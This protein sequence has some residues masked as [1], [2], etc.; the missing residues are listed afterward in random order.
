MGG[1]HSKRSTAVS[2]PVNNHTGLSSVY[3]DDLNSRLKG[4][5]LKELCQRPSAGLTEVRRDGKDN[6][7]IT[8]VIEDEF[9]RCSE[10][11]DQMEF[12]YHMRTY[13]TACWATM[14]SLHQQFLEDETPENER[15][16]LDPDHWYENNL[17]NAGLFANLAPEKIEGMEELVPGRLF[18]TRMP[19]DLIE[20]PGE[21]KD[22]LDKV[23]ENELKVICVLTEAHEFEKY[24][25]DDGLIEFYEKEC[26]LTVYNRAIPDFEIPASGDLVN[27]ILD[28]TYHLSQGRNALIHCAGGTGRTGM[29]LAGVIKNLG[30]YDPVARIR[31]VKSTYVETVEQEKFLRDMPK[32]IDSRIVEEK[33][34]LACAIAAEH[35]IQVFHTHKDTI[36]KAD[37]KKTALNEMEEATDTL[38]SE[39]KDKLNEAY[40]Q[41]FDLLDEDK[42][43]V[44]DRSELTNWFEMCGAE[45]D[46][47]KITETMLGDG[48]LTRAKFIKMMKA[49]AISHRREY[50][51]S[52]SSSGGHHS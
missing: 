20:D 48:K 15:A 22:W 2:V 44:L 31:K 39:E 3:S 33:P 51:I 49:M 10:M 16:R 18:T 38:E 14:E 11:M 47:K 29:V 30:C 35:L 41:V 6:A 28:L 19:R 17:T 7:A 50:D 13:A 26:G 36:K 4:A 23:K 46:V 21:R 32:A 40:G 24:S 45:I 12:V 27:N 8:K 52:G 1:K 34:M 9:N 42:S 5:F 25:G 43:G 37:C